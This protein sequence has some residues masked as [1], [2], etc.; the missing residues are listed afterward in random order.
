MAEHRNEESSPSDAL[1]PKRGKSRLAGKM[2]TYRTYYPLYSHLDT[3][4]AVFTF[5]VKQVVPS[6]EDLEWLYP[7]CL[8]YKK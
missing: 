2:R 3:C 5:L 7:S 4:C 8:L 1:P 6:D